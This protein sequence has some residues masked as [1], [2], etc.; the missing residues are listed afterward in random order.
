MLMYAIY[1]GVRSV[2]LFK[3]EADRDACLL[4]LVRLYPEFD[5]QAGM[6][7]GVDA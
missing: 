5:Y 4:T 7:R 6:S 3:F 1:I 2:A